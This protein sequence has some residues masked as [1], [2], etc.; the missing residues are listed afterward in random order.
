M[1]SL[2]DIAEATRQPL[3]TRTRT[4]LKQSGILW[5]LLMQHE[6]TNLLWLM[7]CSCVSRVNLPRRFRMVM[8][9]WVDECEIQFERWENVCVFMR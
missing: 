3:T 5:Q 1:I 6:I 7:N 2:R 9:A 8:V 4:G